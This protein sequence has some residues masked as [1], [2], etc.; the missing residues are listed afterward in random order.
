MY[1]IRLLT[2]VVLWASCVS[3]LSA[4]WVD[5]NFDFQAGEANSVTGPGEA[6]ESTRPETGEWTASHDLRNHSAN[7][8][9]ER[10]RVHSACSVIF[11]DYAV[12]SGHS[13]KSS[14]LILSISLSEP[15]S[16][17]RW[18]IGA[19]GRD[20]TVGG[21][22]TARYRADGGDWHDAYVYL[23]GQGVFDAPPVDLKLDQPATNLDIGWFAEVPEGERGWW[24]MGDTGTLTFTPA[25]GSSAADEP[26]GVAGPAG[27]NLQ[28]SRFI[29]NS[30]FGTTTH[31]NGEPAIELLDDLRVPNVRVD[32]AW[33]GLEPA[34]GQYNFPSDSWIIESAD[35]GVKHGLDQLV[36]LTRPP[37]WAVGENGTFPNDESVQALEECMYQ[38]AARYKGKIRHWQAMNEPNMAVWGERYIVF[39]KAFHDGVKRADPANQVVLCGFAGVEHTHLDAV[40][41][42]GGKDYFDIIA[43]HAY[44]RPRLPEG[45]GY[46]EKIRAMHDVMTKY[47]D[48]KPLWVTEI[49]WNGVEPS[50]LEYL[51]EKY[52][53]HRS[54]AVT[55]EE[56]ARGLARLY[57][58]SATVPW[59]ERVYFFHLHQ[60]SPY[61]EVMEPV[62]YYM[63]LFTPWRD[64]N[65]RPK[66]AY[67]AVKTVVQVLSEATYKERL[68]LG[69]RVWGL[70]FERGGEATVALWS[71]D[72]GV[73]M[74]L[75]DASMIRSATS[76]VGTPV[77][78]RDGQLPLSGRP[79]YVT[80]DSASVERL[81]SEIEA[82][83]VQGAQRFRVTLALDQEKT[84][85]GQPY[86]AVEVTNTGRHPATPPPVYLQAGPQPWQLAEERIAEDGPLAPG[87]QRSRSVALN[88][89][90][91]GEGE[92][93]CH[94]NAVLFDGDVPLRAERTIRHLVAGARPRGFTADGALDEWRSRTPVTIGMEPRQ[95]EFAGWG[96]REDCSADWY[97]AC[98]RRGVYFAAQITD[99]THHQ[100]LGA[101]TA[102][103]M[104]RYDSVQVGFDAAGDARPVANV[105]QYDGRNDVEIGFG[106]SPDGPL[107]YVWVDPAGK[108]G[109]LWLP[110][111]GI[112]RDEAARTTRYEAAIPW[113]VLGLEQSPGRCWMG[114]NV[115]VNDNDG[116]NRRGWLEWAPGIGHSKDP[117]QFPKVLM[118]CRER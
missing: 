48:R 36:V 62:D 77:L 19:H 73:T 81:K 15:I 23:A 31:V 75:G 103:E 87:E 6:Y 71:L 107:A 52:P 41:R 72:D 40:Y 12:A 35:L 67:F 66:D 118:H 104:W 42:L 112:V 26:I 8:A 91:P 109:P 116:Q 69:A 29:P 47:G 11:H 65:V 20:V 96:G 32:F 90:P 43:S 70:V 7:L 37:Q 14:H 113:S 110:G 51:R 97:C 33:V 94:V 78:V 89:A 99:D 1:K 27:D 105:P 45:G 74:T 46:L 101:S 38:I 98:D 85:P 88:G 22:L 2:G 49:G 3:A 53:G 13:G 34:P 106:L 68:D 58:L 79:I 39:L 21:A 82:A 17:F 56:Q 50:M 28:G 16:A 44:T 57:L 64:G 30:F 54:Y 100:P 83:E 84:R 24:D 115:L 25:Q 5:V 102:N 111:L 9:G 63:G 80:T 10:I 18:D 86:V 55:E 108:I 92:I 60:E 95:R 93:A 4:D 114:M 61:T 117:S 59:V 76:M